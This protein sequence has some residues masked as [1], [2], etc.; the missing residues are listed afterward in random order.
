MKRVADGMQEAISV[1][2]PLWSNSVK[3]TNMD[4]QFAVAS[5]E[6]ETVASVESSLVASNRP[7]CQAAKQSG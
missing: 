1:C 4:D 7:P 3:H 2:V 6:R 5:W